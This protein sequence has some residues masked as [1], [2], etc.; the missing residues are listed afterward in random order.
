M[1]GKF[2]SGFVIGVLV[3]LVSDI[4]YD[5]HK[6]QKSYK[7]EQKRFVEICEQMPDFIDEVKEALSLQPNNL[8]R[9]FFVILE[10][11]CLNAENCFVFKDNG[12]NNYLHKVQLLVDS[13]YVTDITPSNAKMFRMKEQFVDALL[14][15]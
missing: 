4:L 15:K 5:K 1:N 9:D 2:F 3:K 14:G 11:Q 8:V 7:Y 10:W 6:E 13:G 12:I